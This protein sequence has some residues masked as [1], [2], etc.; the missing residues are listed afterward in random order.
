MNKFV[1]NGFS[2]RF[3]TASFKVLPVEGGMF[4]LREAVSLRLYQK[5]LFVGTF[6]MPNTC[7]G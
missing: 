1:V 6:H 5:F 7:P 3:S 2:T 4:G